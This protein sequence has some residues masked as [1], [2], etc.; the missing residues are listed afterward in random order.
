M[1]LLIGFILGV[2]LMC[3]MQINRENEREDYRK[4]I[5]QLSYYIAMR[6]NQ[7]EVLEPEK[8]EGMKEVQKIYEHYWREELRRR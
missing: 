4:D 8:A 6:V 5:R 3:L 7:A 2:I 1:L